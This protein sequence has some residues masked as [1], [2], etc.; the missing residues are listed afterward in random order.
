MQ[1]ELNAAAYIECSAKDM[2]GIDEIVEAL[3]SAK[4]PKQGK[5]KKRTGSKKCDII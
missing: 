4:F 3:I 1:Q 2:S 5:L